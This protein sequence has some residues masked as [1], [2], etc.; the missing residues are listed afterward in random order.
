[1]WRVRGYTNSKQI[2]NYSFSSYRNSRTFGSDHGERIMAI[3]REDINVW[4]RRSP[5]SPAHVSELVNKG[6]KVLVQPSTRRAYTMDEYERAGATISEDLTSASLI[7]GVK[8]VPIDLL[9]P[10]KTYAF[11]S[12]TIKAQE[13]NMPLMDAM[14]EKNIRIIDY[15]KMVDEK[16]RR[17]CAF[18]KFAGVGGMINTLHG[19]GLR[20][21][22]LGHHTPFMYM[23]S[24]HNYKSSRAAKLAAYE[25]GEDIKSGKLPKHFGALSFVFTGSGNVSQGAQEIFQELP[26]V[27]VHPHDLKKAVEGGDHRKLVGTVVRREDYLVPIAGG[28]FDAAEYEAHP[29]R[30][31]SNFAETIAPYMSV[32]INGTYWG[33]EN[34]RLLTNDD[35][36]NLLKPLAR[37]SAYDGCPNLPHRFLAIGDISADPDGSLEFMTECTTIEYPFHLYDIKTG[38]SQI[39]MAGDGVLICSID[40]VPAQLPREATDYFGRLLLPWI[41]EMI[42][43]HATEPFEKQTHLSGTI[44]NAIITSNGTLTPN[45]KYI[46]D[47]RKRIEE[48][49]ARALGPNR[50]VPIT[51]RVLVLGAGMTVGPTIDYLTRDKQ[52]AVTLASNVVSEAEAIA[53]TYRNTSPVMLDAKQNPEKLAQLIKDHDIV[54]SQLPY[55]N[56]NAVARKCIELKTNMISSSYEAVLEPEAHEA[57]KEAGICI[58]MELGLDPG[59]D[60][61]L[62]M[63]C[64]DDVK[65]EGGMITS[66]LSYCGGL[67]APECADNPL[68]YKFSWNPRAGLMTIMHGAK[69]LWYGKTVTVDSGERLINEIR[70]TD[71][72]PGFRLEEYP[73]RD[74]TVYKEKY[75]IQ[76]ADTVIRGTLRYEGFSTAMSGLYQLGFYSL[77]E[78]PMFA[79]AR[80]IP[81]HVLL[82]TI[83]GRPDAGLSELTSLVY[84]KVGRDDAKLQAIKEL[85]LFSDEPVIP[86]KTAFD[87]LA[88]FLKTKLAYKDGERDLVLLRHQ[89]GIEWPEK[90]QETRS[91]TMIQYGDPNGF[92]AMARTVGLPVGIA[93]KQV[94]DGDIKAS[95]VFTPVKREIYKPLVKK[96][97][98]EGITSKSSSYFH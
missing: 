66:F 14:L 54:V 91:I 42:D 41:P 34:P 21:L 96:V 92:S 67:P 46:A 38:S 22:A 44:K 11:F 27:Y 76:T 63:E 75:N 60:H 37:T 70:S 7:I 48:S 95:G 17:V 72:F 5:I 35:A 69:Y 45:F 85:G 56:H 88:E 6:I 31:R 68:R 8:S 59:I 61:M 3:R 13:A 12:H 64:F 51:K 77:R 53:S 84:E 39:G 10:N 74:S 55:E 86:Q 82:A 18:G 47:L 93:T 19:L 9:I 26:H 43:S 58:G 32:L 49:K 20:L 15:E 1:M 97:R 28:K 50:P 24:T 2:L 73:N 52:L 62:A 29:E 83:M 94:M 4:E 80:E 87:T 25:L 23:G 89:I 98:A 81:F 78:H 90:K 33:P 57:A 40:N 16:G 79:E 30:Y 65:E 71:Q 36:K